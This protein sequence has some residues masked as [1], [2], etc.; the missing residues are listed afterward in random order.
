MQDLTHQNE[1]LV[2]GGGILDRSRPA[3]ISI[4][5]LGAPGIFVDGEPLSIPRRQVRSLLYRLAAIGQQMRNTALGLLRLPAFP[6]RM[7]SL[8]NQDSHLAFHSGSPLTCAG[9]SPC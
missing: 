8:Y 5:L 2:L 4:N 1:R 6:M 9:I 7:R 3:A